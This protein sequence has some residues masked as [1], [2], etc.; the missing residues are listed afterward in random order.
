M[1]QMKKRKEPAKYRT[2]YRYPA[3]TQSEKLVLDVIDVANA[4]PS[5]VNTFERSKHY[6]LT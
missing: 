6:F 3:N 1:K 5:F 4:R 2:S